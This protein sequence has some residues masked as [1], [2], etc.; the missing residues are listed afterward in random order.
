MPRQRQFLKGINGFI[1]RVKIAWLEG[2]LWEKAVGFLPT[3]IMF[4][5]D[6]IIGYAQLSK[7]DRRLALSAGFADHRPDKRHY[8]SNP[9]H[10]RRIIAAYKASK[11]A[12]SQAAPPFQIRGMWYEM[13]NLNFQQL[14]DALQS[15]DVAVLATLLEN[16]N[17]ELFTAGSGG[18]G[19]EQDVLYRTSPIG[20]LYMK[21]VW[22]GYRDRLLALDYDL[23]DVHFPLIGNP[24]GI[25]LNGDV[26]QVNVF[27]H[28]Y[29]AVEMRELLRD[30]PRATVVEIGGGA[31]GQAYQTMRLSHGS[32][33]KYLV[34]DI[35][36]VA[37]IISYFLLSAFPEKR[38]RL[39]GEGAVSADPA[40]AYDLGVFPHFAIDNLADHSI[41]LFH[42]ACSFSEMD[43]ASSSEYL[44]VI[45]R[46]CRK[47][48]SH[49]NHDVRL[50]IR[51]ADGSTSENIIGSKLLPDSGLFKR[52]FKKPRVFFLPED[53]RYSRA[54][55]YLYE[56]LRPADN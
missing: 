43:G 36:E 38:I 34:F 19:Y 21:A 33:A 6:V 11:A 51:N 9:D 37:V 27:R 15:E 50:K 53:R 47:Y 49:V 41:D 17:R 24:A 35:P 55:E 16:F 1:L 28:I 4:L 40:E 54:F 23:R 39:F 30:V 10:L 20:H 5:S 44:R 13:I 2:T 32:I 25:Y 46:T 52:V 48:F 56:R 12:Q 42:N 8:R 22:S 7:P 29:H 18:T 3:R 26:I 31:G 14:I 45:E